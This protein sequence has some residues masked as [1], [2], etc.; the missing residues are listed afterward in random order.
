[1]L[2]HNTQ[3]RRRV[4]RDEAVT[5]WE[6]NSPCFLCIETYDKSDT[7]ELNVREFMIKI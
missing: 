2:F 4:A 6:G 1:M 7:I 3:N 5:I